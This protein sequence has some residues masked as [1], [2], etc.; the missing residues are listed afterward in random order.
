MVVV[1]AVAFVVGGGCLYYGARALRTGRA[2]RRL[3]AATDDPRRTVGWRDDVSAAKGERESEIPSDP[4]DD[5]AFER[6]FVLLV[7]GL[8][9]V[10]FGV[11]A[12]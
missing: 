6:G 1:S 10:L 4:P 7:L 9:S 3:D 8:L 2:M 12:W 5:I 11:L